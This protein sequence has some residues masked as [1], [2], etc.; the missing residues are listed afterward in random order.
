VLSDTDA[1]AH[2]RYRAA[3]GIQAARLVPEGS[4]G[5]QLFQLKGALFSATVL[6]GTWELGLYTP[7]PGRAVPRMTLA[8][9]LLSPDG[10]KLA[11]DEYLEQIHAQWDLDPAPYAEA[12]RAGACIPDLHLLPGLAPCYVL[13]RHA[14]VI[15]YDDASVRVALGGGAS[16][17]AT[18]GSGG[19]PA[20]PSP[21]GAAEP[22]A[23]S[24][25]TSDTG[26]SGW[27]LHL[28]R[29]PEADRLIAAGLGGTVP[30]VGWSYPWGTLRAVA[31]LDDAG[32][33]H[34]SLRSER[35]CGP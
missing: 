11:V 18:A 12:G 10:A 27:V 23:T 6:D 34:L 24:E 17:E 25:A 35:G 2:A 30:P 22:A 15:G 4:Q 26:P 9:G 28:D 14:L 21:S 5:D 29:L 3:G 31:T 32:V 7:P 20:G 13:D 19:P 16:G 1:L 33:T 8:L